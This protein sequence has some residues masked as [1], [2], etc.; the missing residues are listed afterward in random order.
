M[1]RFRHPLSYTGRIQATAEQFGESD[2]VSTGTATLVLGEATIP[3]KLIRSDSV[4]ILSKG[5]KNAST[6]TGFLFVES[7]TAGTGFTIAA[8][9]AFFAGVAID[10]GDLSDVSWMVFNP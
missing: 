3:L 8:R 10:T 1:S 5:A 2:R 6:A 9:E 7:Q 4:I